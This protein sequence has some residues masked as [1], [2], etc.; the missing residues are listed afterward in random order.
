[1]NPRIMTMHVGSSDLSTAAVELR[2]V[3]SE[4][5][6]TQRRMGQLLGVAPRS[7]RRWRRGDRHIPHGICILLRLLDMGAITVAQVEEAAGF[8]PRP[9]KGHQKP[10]AAAPAP[11]G[12]G[13][14]PPSKPGPG[15]PHPHRRKSLWACCGNLPLANRR[16]QGFGFL[17]LRPLGNRGV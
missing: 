8:S 6:V 13:A 2:E 7:V 15:H 16:S 12:A 5:S 11:G 17:F 3:L 14:E 4:L 10:R 1:A 9:H